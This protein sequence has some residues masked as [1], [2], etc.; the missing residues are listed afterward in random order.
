MYIHVHVV[1][2]N[3]N[4]H[5]S[6]DEDK[7]DQMSPPS[8]TVTNT[9][10]PIPYPYQFQPTH[11]PYTTMYGLNSPFLHPM[12][13]SNQYWPYSY[14][15]WIYGSETFQNHQPG[16]MLGGMNDVYNTP[17]P[18][19]QSYE[20][21]LDY[22]VHMQETEVKDNGD[23]T[24][25]NA[26]TPMVP[27]TMVQ[28]SYTEGNEESGDVYKPTMFLTSPS[29]T[30][31]HTQTESIAHM[32]P[33][34][35]VQPSVSITPS[36]RISSTD[37][38][39]T[40]VDIKEFDNSMAFNTPLEEV[41]DDKCGSNDHIKDSV[42]SEE[43]VDNSD[44]ENVIVE[45]K[46]DTSSTSED[47]DREQFIQSLLTSLNQD[48]IPIPNPR[49]ESSVP[50]LPYSLDMSTSSD[51]T[52]EF[53]ADIGKKEST[54]SHM[55]LT[56]SHDDSSKESS[57]TESSTVDS[58]IVSTERTPSE[59]S[60]PLSLQEAFLLKKQSFVETSKTRLSELGIRAKE[61]EK[62][63]SK[64]VPSKPS[65]GSGAGTSKEKTVSFSS[66]LLQGE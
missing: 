42:M 62:K 57:V 28:H 48:R 61:R 9:S 7:N 8:T 51:E 44:Q 32:N 58:S 29:D 40:S 55:K 15:P 34:L 39:H 60:H 12:Y 22:P 47:V 18:A 66:P 31:V 5:L 64:M 52:V 56:T 30:H 17:Y 20:T 13:N 4:V 16:A 11:L 50:V 24:G 63:I 10:V 41:G 26:Y 19:T 37:T 35:H 59:K 27:L 25:G 65:S 33:N 54:V 49:N 3:T 45:E 43:K 1:S 6:K 46:K 53:G 38:S 36:S 21:P 2:T 23:V 14:Y